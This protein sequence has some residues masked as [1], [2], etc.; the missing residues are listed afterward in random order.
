MWLSPF[1]LSGGR[2]SVAA[3]I[4]LAHPV[5][6][7]REPAE[8]WA[9]PS[10]HQCTGFHPQCPT[11]PPTRRPVA[12][13]RP[14]ARPRASAQPS[15]ETG[16]A[17]ALDAGPRTSAQPS[18]ESG[19]TCALVNDRGRAR[20]ER[21]TKPGIRTCLALVSWPGTSATKP[22]SRTHLRAR[23]DRGRARTSARPSPEAGRTC[24]LDSCRARARNEARNP[25][26]PPR[27]STTAA[28]R[29]PRVTRRG[30]IRWR[31]R[32][33]GPRGRRWG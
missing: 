16:R 3:P 1:A 32:A 21:A 26:V 8:A 25:D 14:R 17:C 30:R 6:V 22:G 4:R 24:A 20:D 10:H 5:R 19:R 28:G 12:R 29:H 27:S 15:P 31:R 33:R 9:Q 7:T 11:P 2:R 23:H 18:P 13:P